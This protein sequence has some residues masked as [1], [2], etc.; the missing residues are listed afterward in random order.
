VTSAATPTAPSATTPSEQP[1]HTTQR[2]VFGDP[3]SSDPARVHAVAESLLTI[4]DH[5]RKGQR[6]ALSMFNLTYPGAADTLIRAFHRGVEL[7]VLVN[8]DTSRS[9]QVKKLRAVLGTRTGARS[10]VVVRGGGMR[11]HSKFMLVSPLGGKPEVIWISSGN[12][13]NANGLTQANEALIT[14]GDTALYD[15]LITQFDLMRRGINDPG[16]LGRTTTTATTIARTFPVPAGGP[17]N[18]PVEATLENVSCLHGKERTI[19]R[20]AQLLLTKE[21]LYI[22]EQLRVL[23]AAGCD[24]RIVVHL[25]GWNKEGTAILLR[26]GPGRIDLRSA[27][28]AILHTKITTIDGWDASGNR[29]KLAMAGTHNLTG[30]ALTTVPQGYNDELSVT[31]WNPKIVATYSKWVDH[32]IKAHSVPVAGRG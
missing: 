5:A 9:K 30:R 1:Q 7:R 8:I 20:M 22:M 29:L 24:V 19:V 26:P 12:L 2:V 3:W 16:Q 15:F 14:T 23:K 4:V 32:V 10:W 11:M 28:G 31:L 6:I 21:R 27:Q 17:A 25:R 13:T 18:D